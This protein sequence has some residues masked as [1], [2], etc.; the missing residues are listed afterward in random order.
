[1]KGKDEPVKRFCYLSSEYHFMS[2]SW[3][4][5]TEGEYIS[6]PSH[7]MDTPLQGGEYVMLQIAGMF[8]E[9]ASSTNRAIQQLLRYSGE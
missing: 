1:M 9:P 4:V 2:N 7:I 3:S 6:P 8:P 5:K